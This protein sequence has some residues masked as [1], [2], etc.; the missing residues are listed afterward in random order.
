[1]GGDDPPAFQ[2]EVSRLGVSTTVSGPNKEEAR[3]GLEGGLHALMG[4][5]LHRGPLRPCLCLALSSHRQKIAT[6]SQH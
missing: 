5:V 3:Y 4:H 1:M 6:L 2:P